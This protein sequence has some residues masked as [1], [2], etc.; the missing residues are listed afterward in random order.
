ML[1]K[2]TSV[3][4]F[5]G[6]GGS[7]ARWRY[8]GFNALK[9]LVA[10]RRGG[11]FLVL[12]ITLAAASLFAQGP[13]GEVFCA[14]AGE[15]GLAGESPALM[16]TVFERGSWR[17][18]AAYVEPENVTFLLVPAL[19]RNDTDL[20]RAV[21]RAALP[22]PVLRNKTTVCF[23][24]APGT[25][26]AEPPAPGVLI[27]VEKGK[28][29]YH[30]FVAR[31][32]DVENPAYFNLA[33]PGRGEGKRPDRVERVDRRK[34]PRAEKPPE[35][36]IEQMSPLAYWAAFKLYRITTRSLPPGG[37]V[38]TYFDVPEGTGDA[39][40]VLTGGTTP[41][42]YSYVITYV[43]TG[44]TK[45]GSVTVYQGSPQTV[46]AWLGP[47]RATYKVRICNQNSQVAAVHASAL[48]RVANSQYFRNDVIRTTRTFIPFY[49]CNPTGC[50]PLNEWLKTGSNYLAVPGFYVD[51][52][53]DIVIDIYLRV[54]KRATSGTLYV[55]WGGLYIGSIVGQADPRNSNYVIFSASLRVPQGLYPYLLPTYGLGGVI[56]LGPLNDVGG[57]ELSINVGV[58]RPTELAPAGDALYGY[59][60]KIFKESLLVV[61]TRAFIADLEAVSGFGIAMVI[62]TKPFESVGQSSYTTIRMTVKALDS[63]LNPV[64]VAAGTAGVV[65]T[66]GSSWILE[67][68]PWLSL[69]L[70]I[71]DLAKSTIDALKGAVQTFPVIGYVT[72]LLDKAVQSAAASVRVTTSGNA[73]TVELYTGWHNEPL[74]A[75]VT[76]AFPYP[77]AYVFVS[78]V[79]Y[80]TPYV[81]NTVVYSVD[82]PALP[83]TAIGSLPQ[84]GQTTYFPYRTLSCGAQEY[85][86]PNSFKCINE[87]FR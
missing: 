66:S 63:G 59:P 80:S 75:N 33:W 84:A 68:L 35:A 46:V 53:S 69:V 19:T 18:A 76:A 41:G 12:F 81:P 6:F 85:T 32:A 61:N 72:L 31:A 28:S 8:V 67:T 36:K 62:S 49:I 24:A 73:I 42:V 5:K 20:S 83:F 27:A 52:A 3:L 39:A 15:L 45:T 43:G 56:S 23:E 16:V 13:L 40:V 30:V 77:P 70:S 34:P 60:T 26:S 58:R 55:Y 86:I 82:G 14:S 2:A 21:A 1:S 65:V 78:R 54:P 11:W 4:A 10:M 79:E 7:L 87:Y 29:K 44:S 71:Y 22:P 37:C 25:P 57:S 50:V 17:P 64:P 74:A 47:G 51:A 9:A 38:E 48:V